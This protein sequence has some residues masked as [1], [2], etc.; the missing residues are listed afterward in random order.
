MVVVGG[1]VVGLFSALY[2]SQDGWQVVVVDAAA[3][4]AGAARGS[5]GWICPALSRPMAGPGA[6]RNAVLDSLRREGAVRVHAPPRRATL[7]WI[8][9][10]AGFSSD[11]ELQRTWEH[12]ARLSEASFADWRHIEDRGLRVTM[13]RS[14]NLALFDDRAAAAAA[15]EAAQRVRTLGQV[16]PERL[17]DGDEV[18]ALEPAASEAVAAGYLWP[19][20]WFVDPAVVMDALLS[21]VRSAGVEIREHVAVRAVSR[22]AAGASC[23]T[24]GEDVRADAVLIATGADATALLRPLGVAA[25][26]IHGKGYSFDVPI[27]V[28][29]QHALNLH[30]PHIA[31]T[32]L[33]DGRL[34]VAGVMEFDRDDRRLNASGIARIRR[35]ASPYLRGVD[36]EDRAHEW[37]GSRPMTPDTLP[38]VGWVQPP[39]PGPDTPTAGTG[40]LVATG[41]GTMGLTQAPGTA[42]LVTQALNG[43][44]PSW[45]EPFDPRRF[46]R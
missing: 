28:S 27:T 15:F 1:G 19:G 41:H 45:A 23:H 14:G 30:G 11:R 43:T 5:G 42:R 39:T 37:V 20:Q 10:F 17:L 4:G 6:V 16:A 24:D 18:R 33:S 12:A 25:P 9:R 46:T 26:V 13:G 29:P 34:R 3:P 38:L 8:A 44:M 7:G 32:P 31:A 36:W 22:T 35:G 21:A 40:I 2:A